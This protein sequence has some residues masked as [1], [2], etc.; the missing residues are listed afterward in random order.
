MNI[1]FTIDIADIILLAIMFS[2]CI[3]VVFEIKWL[4]WGASGTMLFIIA[5]P[6]LRQLF[7]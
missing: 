6:Y 4:W 2:F 3:G 7:L 5:Y 1:K